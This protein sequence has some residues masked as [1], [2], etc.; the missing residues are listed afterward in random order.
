MPKLIYIVDDD[1]QVLHLL[2][3]VLKWC[4]STWVIREFAEPEEALEAVWTQPP[5]LVISDQ[6]MP[7]MEGGVLLEKVRAVAPQT[8]RILISGYV[9]TSSEIGAAHQ[10]L[11]KPFRPQEVEQCVLQAIHA[12]ERLERSSMAQTITGLRSFPVIPEIYSKLMSA[13]EGETDSVEQMAAILVQDGGALTRVL[14]VANSPMFRGGEVVTD[15]IEGISLLG[16]QTVKALSLSFH[17]FASYERLAIPELQVSSLWRHSLD[18]AQLARMLCH[19]GGLGRVEADAAFF[20]GLVHSLGCLILLENFPE[21]YRKVCAEAG[22]SGRPLV[23]VESEQLPLNRTEVT[24]FL[25][26]LWGMDEMMVEAVEFHG[27]PWK[28]PNKA[29]FTPADAVYV[30]SIVCRQ[31]SPPDPFA[32]PQM[33]E[34]YVERLGIPGWAPSEAGTTLIE[35]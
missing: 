21:A 10:Y 27:A 3:Q 31:N 13:L 8:V 1:P 30:A 2:G 18:T 4:D 20:A 12:Q 34:I 33:E 23:V 17:V 11:A 6:R 22:A 28:Q 7:K 26:R 15:A 16:T 25:L 35:R 14:Q 9:P 32:T 5:H 19:D 24:A 29:R